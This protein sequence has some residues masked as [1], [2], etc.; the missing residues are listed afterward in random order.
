MSQVSC[1][2][3]GRVEKPQL[4]PCETA[5]LTLITGS[6]L[7]LALCLPCSSPIP[8]LLSLHRP[9]SSLLLSF[10]AGGHFS[11]LPDPK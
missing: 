7:S 11:R 1:L 4:P 6:P 5:A 9:P 8:I 3:S 2:C 10:L